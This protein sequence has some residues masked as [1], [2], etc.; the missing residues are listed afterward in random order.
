M[1]PNPTKDEQQSKFQ[2]F[3]WK[4]LIFLVPL[5]IAIIAVIG[6]HPTTRKSDSIIVI[7]PEFKSIQYSDSM[8]ES[9]ISRQARPNTTFISTERYEVIEYTIESGDTIFSV[10]EKFGLEPETILWGNSE[11]FTDSPFLG[12]LLDGPT[13]NI[14]P[15]DGAY[16]QFQDG[17]SLTQLAKIYDVSVED[18]VY[19][20]GNHLEI[21]FSTPEET[22]VEI[23][24]W[25]LIPG[26]TREIQYSSFPITPRSNPSV[27]KYYV[28][29]SCDAVNY[30]GP[31]GDGGFIWPAMAS[32][33]SGYNWTPG[34]HEAIDIGGAE[35]SPIYAADDGVV[36]YADWSEYGYGN[37]VLIDHGNGWH[38][39]YAHLQEIFVEC[40]D[41]VSQGDR[42]GEL[43]STGNVIEPHLHFEMIFNGQNF[44]PM[45]YVLP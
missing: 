41:A 31:I 5:A 14:L 36:V 30:D 27:A 38:T 24:A 9:A 25:L 16:I 18:I 8:A 6:L 40:G 23:G 45:D 1:T 44:N 37:M 13:I 7:M 21:N 35:G 12:P 42:I 34:I 20:P 15:V 17:M 19:F 39:A 29:S 10:A 11:F 2:I 28:S 3:S 43:G 32:F 22:E 4:H 33:I 26:G